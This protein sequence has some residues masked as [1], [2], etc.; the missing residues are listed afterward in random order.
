[1]DNMDNKTDK[2]KGLAMLNLSVDF[3]AMLNGVSRH[4]FLVNSAKQALVEK[5]W[6]ILTMIAGLLAEE[7]EKKES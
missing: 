1:M 4:E 7:S 3:F 5:E 2:E 6:G